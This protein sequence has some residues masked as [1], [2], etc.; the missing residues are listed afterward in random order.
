MHSPLE[1]FKIKPLIPLFVGGV[2]LSFTNASLFMLLAALLPLAILWGMGRRTQLVPG[3][4]QA[5][6]EK[7]YLFIAGLVEHN[8]GEEGRP[9]FPLIFSVFMFVFFGN[10]LGMLP[11][12]FTFTSQLAI[13]FGLAGLLFLI[14]TGIG[15]VRHGVHFM[16]IFW[17]Q[18]VPWIL[19]PLLVP[20][21]LL[22]YLSRPVSLAI[23]LFANMMAGHTMMK[24]FGGFTVMLGV[25]GVLP[26]A[27]NVTLTGFEIMVSF[28]QAYVFTILTCIYLHDAIYLHQ[29]KPKEI[30]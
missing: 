20:I 9:Y 19:A 8:T 18:G 4:L 15:F 5:A 23:R 12:G 3:L 7:T 11:F 29:Q 16:T 24:V 2:D 21:E 28:L 17:P 1:Q 6:V 26:F 27:L 30:G 10:M 14:I 25:A 22:S 13:V